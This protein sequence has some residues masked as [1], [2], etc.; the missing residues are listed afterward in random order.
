M[1]HHLVCRHATLV[2]C[3][4]VGVAAIFLAGCTP[5]PPYWIGGSP[6]SPLVS[7]VA[8]TRMCVVLELTDAQRSAAADL[9]AAYVSQHQQAARKYAD[10]QQLAQQ[11]IQREGQEKDQKVLAQRDEATVKYAR[12][13]D[14]LAD[15]FLGDFQ[16]LL[17][18]QQ[19]AKWDAAM[20]CL[21]RTQMLG[22]IYSEKSADL[23][24][25]VDG[26]PPLVTPAQRRQIA[27]Q[28]D[29][30]EVAIDVVLQ[31]KAAFIRTGLAENLRVE[32]ENDSA[33]T[34]AQYRR[35]RAIIREERTL[36]TRSA[37]A[38]AE[39]LPEDVGVSLR[40]KV[41][42]QT[43]PGLY[44]LQGPGET[45]RK[46]LA[47]P[48]LTPSAKKSLEELLR[49]TDRERVRMGE[50]AAAKFEEWE[51]TASDDELASRGDTPEV[52]P[53]IVSAYTRLE[54]RVSKR[55]GEVLTP[56]QM[57]EAGVKPVLKS[58]PGI[59]FE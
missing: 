51:R 3:C 59:D 50:L 9:H 13:A 54:E 2:L 30:W 19:H 29:D 47:L 31:R 32:R 7:P 39:A 52:P 44:E 20:R 36:T 1:F 26:P 45:V 8:L 56:E 25:L 34:Q 28:L 11:V 18:D 4:L 5:R 14:K 22:P 40:R 48:G 12:Y 49:E 37:R 41:H 38:I 53:E 21:R 57:Q 58:L 16:L 24:V 35:W 27:A 33:G 6:E 17:T 46:A 10:Y 23:V 42:E 55:L 15:Q 43:Y